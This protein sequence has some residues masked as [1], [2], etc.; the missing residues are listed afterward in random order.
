MNILF[1]LIISHVFFFVH[2]CVF[3]LFSHIILCFR[4]IFNILFSE[5]GLASGFQVQR[6]AS[7]SDV[8]V[9]LQFPSVVVIVTRWSGSHGIEV[10]N[11]QQASVH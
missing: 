9:L 4:V 10:Y 7:E 11:D 1:L 3:F 2:I 5:E 6:T 8:S